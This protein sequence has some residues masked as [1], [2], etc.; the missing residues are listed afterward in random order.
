MWNRGSRQ[1]RKPTIPVWEARETG[2][3]EAPGKDASSVFPWKA[4]LEE[5]LEPR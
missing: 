4:R 2:E 1:A 5:W 3:E